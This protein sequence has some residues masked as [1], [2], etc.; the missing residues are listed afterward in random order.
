MTDNLHRKANACRAD[1]EFLLPIIPAEWF[2]K[3]WLVRESIETLENPTEKKITA[4]WQLAAIIHEEI[5]QH[6]G[7]IFCDHA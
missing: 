5:R 2:L 3:K 6:D 1:L 7:R 4:A